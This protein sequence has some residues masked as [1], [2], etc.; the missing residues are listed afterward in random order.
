MFAHY[1]ELRRKEPWLEPAVCWT[2]VVPHEPRPFSVADI[3]ARV[4]GGTPHEVHEAA[5]LEALPFFEG[6]NPMSVAPASPAVMLFE[7]NGILGTQRDVLRRLSRDGR[8]CGVYWNV[9]GDNRLNY[10]AGGRVLASLDAMFWDEWS[11]DD[12]AVLE[13]E[14]RAMTE[15]LA[16]DEDDWRA[17]A[18]A[19]VEL[20]TGVRLT[21]E[22]LSGAHPYLTFQWPLA[23]EPPTPEELAEYRN[24]P[25]VRLRDA[26]VAAPESRQFAALTHLAELLATRFRL[27]EFPVV[28]DVLT[29]LASGRRAGAQRVG[30]LAERLVAP[31]AQEA[32]DDDDEDSADDLSFEQDPAWQRMQAGIALQIAARG[33]K[34]T[35][36]TAA[37][38]PMVF[39]AYHH[40]GL[41]LGDDWPAVRETIREILSG[42]DA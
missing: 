34:D 5:P 28:R 27:G 41:A 8:V 36:L 9:E 16:G 17:A 30:E 40:A 4:S 21:A 24:D 6:G 35:A 3:G 14:L 15:L 12:I 25:E 39:D 32:F 37:D 18:M 29:G 19:V 23:T 22:W 2:V 26:V 33:P 42:T 10:A 31:L 1:R 11:G 13:P 20:V 7:H 38:I